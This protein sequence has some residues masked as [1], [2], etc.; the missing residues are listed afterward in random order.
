VE[1]LITLQE[2]L[3]WPESISVWAT[4]LFVAGFPVVI[5]LAWRRDLENRVAKFGLAALSLV[6]AGAALWL[7]W[8]TE[9]PTPASTIKLPPVNETIA[10]VAVLPF[11]NG[12]GDPAYDYLARGFTGELIGRLSKHPDLAVIQEQS[13]N[14]PMLGSLLPVAKATTLNAD[15][16]VQGRLRREGKFI[17]VNANLEDLNGRVLW[18]E[19]LREPYSAESVVA[20]QR[21]I[22]GEISRVLGTGLA[23]PAYCGETTD[24]EAMELYY[25]GR[26]KIGTR[27]PDPMEAGL[28]LLKQAV[29][30]DPYFGRAWGELGEAQLV[31]SSYQRN[32][33]GGDMQQAGILRSMSMAAFRRALDVC[34]TLGGAY[35]ILVPPFDGID[36]ES[37]NQEM[38]WREALAMDPND[39]ALLRQYALH[40]MQHGMNQQAIHAM[41]R[42]YENEPLL[43]MIPFQLAHALA[44]MG[45][46]EEALPLAAESEKLGG[47]P[48][49]S[50]EMGCANQSGDPDRIVADYEELPKIGMGMPFEAMNLSP[51]E[52]ARAVIDTNH[53]AR[54]VI[55]KKMRGLWEENPDAHK[56][57]HVYWMLGLATQLGNFDLIFDILNGFLTEAG[58]YPLTVA[59]T[60]LF[61]ASEP[62][63]RLR[64]DPRFLEMLQK[65]G[66]PEYWRKYGW[67]NGCGPAGDDFRCF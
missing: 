37:I 29:D 33:D 32:P 31:L 3:G 24:L 8:S 9:A 64:S 48:R 26:F 43:A 40:L 21:R 42:A 17:E 66:Y 39:A 63:G 50:I 15:F 60:P 28:K 25:R 18:S 14:A 65:T 58:F 59:W 11:E 36:N 7:T 23:T 44:K 47:Q 53:P 13:V 2:K 6:V 16:L 67:P 5:I 12:S 10:T 38:Q 49:L 35:K 4:R 22:S 45:R 20:L 19:I 51:G 52:V 34:P 1:I 54:P 30:K 41:Q 27:Q 46:C 62:A 56:N 55:G 57:A 61:D